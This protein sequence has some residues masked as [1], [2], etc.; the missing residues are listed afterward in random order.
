[1][2]DVLIKEIIIENKL[3]D[4]RRLREVDTLVSSSEESLF[5]LLINGGYIQEETILP[6]IA[7]KFGI[8]FQAIDERFECTEELMQALPPSVL[9]T[10][11]VIPLSI[12][13]NVLRIGVANPMF[14]EQVDLIEQETGFDVVPALVS[15][16]ILAKI[17]PVGIGE[18]GASDKRPPLNMDNKSLED[19]ANEAPIIKLVNLII[20]RAISEGASDIHIEP[21]EKETI[22]RHR[23]DGVLREVSK[24][25]VN[26]SPAIISR[27]K[28]M[29]NLNIAERR[30]PQDG[31]ISLRLMDRNFDLRVATM[32]VLHSE[33]VVMRI[34]D[35]DNK[36]L[37]LRKMGFSSYNLPLFIKHINQPHGILLLTGPT[38]SG[39]TTTLNAAISDINSTDK[40]IITIEDPV[41]YEIKGVS[42][43]HVN[44]KVGLSF[45]TGL[46]SILRLDPDVVMIGEIRDTETAEIA[47]RTAL[48]GH[49]VFSTLHTNTAPSAVTRL[50]DMNIEPYLISSCLNGVLAQRLIR[51]VCPYCVEQKKPTDTEKRLLAEIGKENVDAVV[52]AKGCDECNKSGYHGRVA[53]HEFFELT[54]AS[55]ELINQRVSTDILFKEAQRA[56]MKPLREDGIEKFLAGLTTAEEVLRVTEM[57]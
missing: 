53:I 19:L 7:Q 5:D 34:L 24:H 45:A 14:I 23:I 21:Y 20:M 25:S 29:A 16:T 18:D 36:I 54:D 8:A 49:L 39:K 15:K 12:N 51:R 55:R 10:R 47:I 2:D 11:Q 44:S 31:R 38:G 57:D 40:K 48:T 6:L 43:I 52:V 22:V 37:N 42:Q 35:K 26:E 3:L 30:I 27:I 32:P 41:E 13:E 56:G 4:E 9:Q 50:I 46:R 33:G 1:M 28:I 17:L